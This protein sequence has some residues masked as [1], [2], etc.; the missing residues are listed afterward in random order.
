MDRLVPLFEAYRSFYRCA[1]DADTAAAFL[2]ERLE[3]NESVI[4]LAREAGGEIVGF[5]QLYPLFSSTRM[6]RTWLLND[7]FVAPTARRRGVARALLKATE[8]FAREM[9]AGE[10]TLSTSIGNRVAQRVYATAG[11]RRDDEFYTYI[12]DVR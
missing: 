2:R 5:A 12:R 7:L 3:R 8:D 1:P 9:G 10:L 6:M 11:W 4:L